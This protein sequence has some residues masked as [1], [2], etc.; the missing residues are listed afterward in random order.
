[1]RDY[2]NYHP[3]YEELILESGKFTFQ[4]QLDGFEG[5]DVDI[6]SVPTRALVTYHQNPL[7]EFKESRKITVW[8]EELINRGSYV[9]TLKDNRQFLVIS[10]VNDNDLIKYALMRE[11][12]HN[13]KWINKNNQLITR[14]CIEDARTLYT[15]GVKDEKV[16]EIPNGMV[17]IQLPY[18][19]ET[20]L[21]DR[22]DCFVFNKTKYKVTFYDE[23]TFRGLILLICTETAIDTVKDD[24]TNEI[25]DRWVEIDGKRVDR[26]PWLDDQEPPIEPEPTEPTQGITYAITSV[27]KY[28]KTDVDMIYAKDW[29]KYTI[30][31]FVDDV[32]VSGTFT[33]EIDSTNLATIAVADNIATITAKDIRKGG[34]VRLTI[35][36]TET[37]QIA[38]EKVIIIKG[39]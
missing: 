5:K 27:D 8:H 16:I 20:K 13:L 36:D 6:D 35:V 9:K 25:A 17:G 33:F 7:N 39:Y 18:D 34:D 2:S 38:I 37:N 30:H 10:E 19:D 12:N 23:T 15:T 26:L 14:P 28:G 29:C 11:T 4:K 32:E 3:T 22:E 21:L 24:E 1:M 31:K